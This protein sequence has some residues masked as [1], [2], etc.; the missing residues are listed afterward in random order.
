[1]DCKKLFLVF[2][3]YI[4]VVFP[5]YSTS[6]QREKKV[7]YKLSL[8]QGVKQRYPD[9][10]V[11]DLPLEG[12][13]NVVITNPQDNQCVSWDTSTSKWINQTISGGGGTTTL[14]ASQTIEFQL[15]VL[16][17]T[18]LT[19][20]SAN[21]PVVHNISSFTG[22]G[23]TGVLTQSVVSNVG[24]ITVAQSGY[25]NIHFFDEIQITSSTAGGSGSVGDLIIMLIKRDSSGRLV[26]EWSDVINIEDPISSAIKFPIEIDPGLV[27][28]NVGDYFTMEV[29]FV[30]STA[31]RNVRFQFPADNP[32][33]VEK[34]QF[35]Y[36]PLV[37]ISPGS[38]R[39]GSVLTTLNFP[40]S[41]GDPGELLIMNNSQT[42]M[43]FGTL[44]MGNLNNTPSAGVAN[45]WF[46][47]DSTGASVEYV[48]APSGGGGDSRLIAL[49]NEPSD[50][51]SYANGQVLRVNNPDPGKWLEIEG[52]NAGELHGFSIDVET[53]S[54]NPAQA[55]WSVGTDLNFGYSSFG[56][57]FGKLYTEDRGKPFSPSNTPIMRVEIRLEVARLPVRSSQ[58]PGEYGFTSGLTMLIRKTDL[59]SAPATL[60]VRMYTGKPANDNEVDTVEMSKGADNPLHDYHTYLDSNNSF[61]VTE[62]SEIESIKYFRIFTSNPSTTD[63]SSNPLELHE[64]KSVEEIDAPTTDLV[65]YDSLPSQEELAKLKIDQVIRVKSYID[66]S[67][68]FS[69]T[70]LS[71]WRRVVAVTSWGHGIR[72]TTSQNTDGNRRGFSFMRGNAFGTSIGY[73]DTTRNFNIFNT[74]ISRI[75]ISSTGSYTVHIS[76]G[77][78]TTALQNLNTIYMRISTGVPTSSN[79][80]AIIT[81]TK[82]SDVYNPDDFGTYQTYTGT[83]SYSN[84]QTWMGVNSNILYFT[85][86]TK[87]PADTSEGQH[88][89]P[90]NFQNERNA[91]VIDQA[92]S[93]WAFANL[94]QI[95]AY[96][97][98]AVYD[99][100]PTYTVSEADTNKSLKV[101]V[102]ETTEMQAEG[103][104][105]LNPSTVV[106]ASVG[107]TFKYN[108]SNG[109]SSVS[110]TNVVEIEFDPSVNKYKIIVRASLVLTMGVPFEIQ[111]DGSNYNL[112]HDSLL[113]ASPFVRDVYISDTIP[114]DDRVSATDLSK[115]INIH[116]VK[117]LY[118]STRGTM[119]TSLNYF[120]I[121]AEGTPRGV[122]YHRWVVDDE[123]IQRNNNTN[124]LLSFYYFL[125]AY[126]IT[127]N[128][129][130]IRALPA[131]TW[132]LKIDPNP[133]QGST[134]FVDRA[135]TISHFIIEGK[136]FPVTKLAGIGGDYYYTSP[137]TNSYY[138]PSY[139][140]FTNEGS[141]NDAKSF[142]VKYSD[143]TY[144]TTGV[145]DSS[146]T[147]YSNTG[148]GGKLYTYQ[149][150]GTPAVP[151]S[152]AFKVLTKAGVRDWIDFDDQIPTSKLCGKKAN[153]D[154]NVLTSSEYTAATKTTGTIFCVQTQ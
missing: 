105:T 118:G 124:Y 56:S 22:L 110:N 106:F 47:W 142:N 65:A 145:Y 78:L 40:S 28:L 46:K 16:A 71:S 41:A 146:T 81:L 92:P 87:R 140:T 39:P 51:S 38:V 112:T 5:L 20:T 98:N 23:V 49:E 6:A 8:A 107:G 96:K 50:L 94:Q 131:K 72:A 48:D 17:D 11:V 91:I 119:R 144:G 31:S 133:S 120:N 73:I 12:L 3:T 76:K 33:L 151:E 52:A 150:P 34:L 61:G 125:D 79:D 44:S 84:F 117:N 126:N 70:I 30:S 82:G 101:A 127:N 14:S 1:M 121:A 130:S 83:G 122:F 53:D 9:A 114:S 103:M 139:T 19:A 129:V 74:P 26:D 113:T 45:K 18:T 13:N 69:R 55:S 143:G 7:S 80:V 86:F 95:P 102:E 149:T 60:F 85:F 88:E 57:V 108:S 77:R 93:T 134:S 68:G 137:M 58:G 2:L 15:P 35:L 99:R 89:N 104:P 154:P 43:D 32:N 21:T 37:S 24:R 135:K 128:F 152:R 147:T 90:F 36:F 116:L 136:E 109:S 111:I 54:N 75:F 141:T 42:G 153:G 138:E 59:T 67:F 115:S 29:E 132:V 4:I 62:M 97:L 63:Q 25:A 100:L 64:N 27:A 66:N 10:Q 148:T 123:S